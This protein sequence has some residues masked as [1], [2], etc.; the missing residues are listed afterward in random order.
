MLPF[1]GAFVA[2]LDS[3]NRS[4]SSEP[5]RSR[6]KWILLG[7]LALV[8]LIAGGLA[9]GFAPYIRHRATASA[10]RYGASVEIGG[11]VPF[12]KGVVLKDVHVTLEDF[13]ASTIVLDEVR[14]ES[15]SPR[16]VRVRGGHVQVEGD[17]ADLEREVAALRERLQK[18]GGGETGGTSTDATVEGLEVA[19]HTPSDAIEAN[20]SGLSVARIDG[21]FGITATEAHVRFKAALVTARGVH[22]DLARG[23]GG[24]ALTK[25]STESLDADVTAPAS[26]E[27]GNT[28]ASNVPAATSA[29]RLL[30]WRERVATIAPLL[31]AKLPPGA[32][33]EL[34]GVTAHIHRGSDTLNFGPGALRLSRKDGR[35]TGEY[36]SGAGH[37][38]KSLRLRAKVPAAGEPLA[39]DVV[40]GPITLSTLGVHDGDMKL[41]DV[42][43]T[44]LT[45]NLHVELDEE[46][47][48]L[49]LD[50]DGTVADLGFDARSISPDPVRGMRLSFRGKGEADLDGGHA[51]VT[52][53]EME[54]GALQIHG[55]F[56]YQ[57]LAAGDEKNPTKF[58]LR[59][60]FK[61]PLTACQTLLDAAPKGLLPT[62]SGTQMA[63]SIA[64]EGHANLDTTNLD[65]FYDLDWVMNT[66]CRVTSV[67]PAIDVK[68]FQHAFTRTVYTPEGAK[69]DIKAGPGSGSWANYGHISHFMETGVMS[70]EDAGFETHNGF[71]H[72]A[73]RNSIRENLRTGKF[74][75]GASTISMQLAKNLYLSRDKTISRKIEEAILTMYLEQT[76]TKDQIME[77]YLNVVELGPMIYG[78]ESAASHYFHSTAGQ[79]SLSQAFYLASILP[80]PQQQHFGADGEVSASWM[81]RL[82]TVMR[83]ANKRN[84]VTGDEL[85]EGLSE[86][87]V[88]GSPAPMKDPK[89]KASNHPGEGPPDPT[90]DPVVFSEP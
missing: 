19:L 41:L 89:A 65:K 56:D 39:V 51:N 74:V 64:L 48:T 77:L 20:L 88:F 58:K 71:D 84:R 8:G 69:T 16:V 61:I 45:S 1:E 82:R 83:Y 36:E 62:V 14:V 28:A 30:A 55:D 46:G 7:V 50:G 10:A 53:G 70:F 22:V 73:I 13:P 38:G 90:T 12:W 23:D 4:P 47:K 15:G 31:D 54:I 3:V 66:S 24:L 80:A 85:D 26:E 27:S 60:T 75:R 59:S 44:T 76:L 72:E 49:R 35:L 40:G 5:S 68:N 32:S 29:G 52:G 43:T 2:R 21:G 67:P 86:I 57:R 17:L 34:A 63:G 11:V 25:L 42:D 9:L 79:L 37:D 78:V 18:L 6:W 81:T 87:V 33:V